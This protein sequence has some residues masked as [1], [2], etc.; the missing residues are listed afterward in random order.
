M[1]LRHKET[2]DEF[3]HYDGW[4][5]K[6]EFIDVIDSR[7]ELRMFKREF[8]EPVPVKE[9]WEDVNE[10]YILSDMGNPRIVTGAEQAGQNY[11]TDLILP[12]GFRLVFRDGVTVLQR[13]KQ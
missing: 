5:G 1:K 13:R 11:C 4:D 2:G 3:E 12:D 6:R 8:I 10:D 7:G 9:E